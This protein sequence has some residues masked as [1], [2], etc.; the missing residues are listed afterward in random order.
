MP[1]V[2]VLVQALHSSCLGNKGLSL[3]T[4]WSSYGVSLPMSAV[5]KWVCLFSFWCPFT[6]IS[7][8]RCCTQRSLFLEPTS[9]ATFKS[10]NRIHEQMGTLFSFV[11]KCFPLF[12][13]V[14][15]YS[16]PTSPC[17]FS[18]SHF[19]NNFT[20]QTSFLPSLFVNLHSW[21]CFL[22]LRKKRKEHWAENHAVQLCK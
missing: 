16:W 3:R 15:G 5:L 20:S 8:L 19:R 4:C 21:G 7:Q 9:Q 6:S 11:C 14:S 13:P 12:L 10:G 1:I 17:G 2:R 22:D 18:F